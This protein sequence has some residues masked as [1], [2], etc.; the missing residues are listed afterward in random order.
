[1]ARILAAHLRPL[2]AALLEK[3]GASSPM[4]AS[5]ARALVAAEEEGM[6]SHGLSRLPQ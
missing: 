5:T 4:A 6:P 1:M 3:G 2:V